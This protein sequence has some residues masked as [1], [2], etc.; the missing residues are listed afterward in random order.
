VRIAVIG[1]GTVGSGV[2]AAAA[3]AGHE[4]VLA[5]RHPEH[6]AAVAGETGARAAQTADA[7]ADGADM[8]VLAVPST[9]V[10][11][12][13]D[14][15]R[16]HVSGK[17]IVDPTNPL[18]TDLSGVLE[19]TVSVAEEIAILLPGASVVKAFN[20]VL[21]RRL[22]EPVVDG[23]RLDGFYAGNDPRANAAVAA[24][25]AAMGF[26][27]LDA[28]LLR[29]ARSLEHLGFL[30]VSLNARHGWSWSSGWKLLGDTGDNDT[31]DRHPPT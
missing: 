10:A 19:A 20:T 15:I 29:A 7:A 8:V 28:G 17:I 4:V 14:Q 25:V 30:N 9:A 23:V 18:E 22:T 11:N 12:V 2:A 3:K 27:P 24:L 1:T 5:S 31:P 6:A 26:R 16:R 21:G 13:C